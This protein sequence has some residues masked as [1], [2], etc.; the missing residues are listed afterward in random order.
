MPDI[1]FLTDT[2]KKKLNPQN[3]KTFFYLF[4]LCYLLILCSGC[5]EVKSPQTSLSTGSA[6]PKKP[7]YPT[8]PKKKKKNSSQ[9]Q[10]QQL[11]M[12]NI[13]A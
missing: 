12:I 5:G 6:A 2:G 7:R 3:H 4:K 11:V 13:L 1:P 9:I 10:Q 8:L